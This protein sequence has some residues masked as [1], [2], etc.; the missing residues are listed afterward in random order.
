M[1]TKTDIEKYFI[2]EKSGGLFLIIIGIAAIGL[3][4]VYSFL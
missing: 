4:I 3:A 2:A 1:F